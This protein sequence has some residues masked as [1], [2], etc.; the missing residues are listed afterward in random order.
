MTPTRFALIF[1]GLVTSIRLAL[2]GQIELSADE[3]YYVLWSQ[4]LDWSYFSKGPGVAFAIRAGAALFGETEFGVRF[5]SPLLACG[6]GLLLFFF[7]RHLYGAAV[8]AWA[9]VLFNLIPMFQ[10]G[11]LLMTIDPLSMFF[12]LA[13]LYA[14]WIALEHAP[15]FSWAWP[16]AGLLVGLGFLSKYTNAMQLLSV[17]L[18]LALNPRHRGEF[19]R[20]G[21]W[22]LI[23]A[24]LICAIPPVV[25]NAGHD[26]VTMSH[27]RARGG[28][29]GTWAFR[30][31]ECLEFIAMHIGV[32]SPLIFGGLAFAL[33]KMGREFS[34]SPKTLY[35]AA[36]AFPLILLYLFLSLKQVGEANWT[37]PAFISLG[38][39]AAKTWYD[40]AS[41]KRWAAVYS[42]VALGLGLAMSLGAIQTDL[43]RLA[44]IPWPHER[45]PSG[46]LRGWRSTADYVQGVRERYERETGEKV[47]LIGSG[48][49]LASALAFYLPE[50]RVE[51]P[52]HPPVYIPESQH[53]EN[54]YSFWPRYDEYVAVN[55]RPHAAKDESAM[56][57][58]YTE[59][60]GVNRF[61]GRTALYVTERPQMKPPGSIK[62]GFEETEM[63]ALG[64]IGRRGSLLREIRIFVCRNYRGV[65]L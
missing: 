47:F 31:G 42:A 12:W 10:A 32:Y 49:Q 23:L 15:R 28:L 37:A 17:G 44:G 2:I 58:Y 52:G 27:L 13:A 24:F 5:L 21:F 40:L 29:T 4:K 35:L 20:A 62:S 19:A 59:E 11:G 22:S 48:Y 53:I 8:A 46:R 41:A 56:D 1:I 26:W 57:E 65:P 61:V 43:F 63:I 14:L 18:V 45:D 36:F 39:F 64:R 50:R 3:A 30:P 51:F 6:T 9:V 16:A 33:W 60:Q 38:I 55:E 7:T 25:W 54:Q 34:K